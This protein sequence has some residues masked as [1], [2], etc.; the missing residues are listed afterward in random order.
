[1]CIR[2]ISTL[3]HCD[4]LPT[5]Q[6]RDITAIV[7]NVMQFKSSCKLKNSIQKRVS[8]LKDETIVKI[9]ATFKL[10]PYTQ[11]IAVAFV[12][13]MSLCGNGAAVTF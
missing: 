12:A 2:L 9:R 13:V 1:M 11:N 4:G 8:A 6:Q 10:T 5:L 3:D 7:L